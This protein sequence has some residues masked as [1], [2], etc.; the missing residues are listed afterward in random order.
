M[1]IKKSLVL[2]S[3]TSGYAYI[4][5]SATFVNWAGANFTIVYGSIGTSQVQYG[6]IINYGTLTFRTVLVTYPHTPYGDPPVAETGA[7]SELQNYGS[8]KLS[9]NFYRAVIL[10]VLLGDIQIQVS[11]SPVGVPVYND[12]KTWNI[13]GGKITVRMVQDSTANTDRH[14]FDPN[15]EYNDAFSSGGAHDYYECNIDGDLHVIFDQ[16]QVL[17]GEADRP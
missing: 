5:N 17:P 14:V 7:W 13:M 6:T 8:Y 10:I 12:I 11:D 15:Y 1:N 9:T 16:A 4:K 3:K 2:L